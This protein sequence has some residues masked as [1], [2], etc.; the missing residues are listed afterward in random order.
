MLYRYS[1]EV[2]GVTFVVIGCLYILLSSTIYIVWFKNRS[3]LY[4]LMV[5]FYANLGLFFMRIKLPNT[6]YPFE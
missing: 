4:Y 1:I 3:F 5:F 6:P 2:V